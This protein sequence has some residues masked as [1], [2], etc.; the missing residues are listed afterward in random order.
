MSQIAPEWQALKPGDLMRTYRYIER[1]EPLGW[2]VVDVDEEHALV[3]RSASIT[4]S[5]ALILIPEAGDRSRLVARTRAAR[6]SSLATVAGWFTGEPMHFVMEV[7]VLRGVKHRA[8]L[9]YAAVGE[10]KGSA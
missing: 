5:W 7:G 6:S 9:A 3:V 1:F 8:E 10:T 4:W 2:T